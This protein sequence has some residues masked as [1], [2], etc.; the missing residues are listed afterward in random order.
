MVGW[1]RAHG[2]Q[3]GIFKTE[4]PRRAVAYL[5]P[6]QRGVRVFLA[7]D[8]GG[9]PDL[10]PTPSTSTWAVRF[11]SVFQIAGEQVVGLD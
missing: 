10:Q 6:A 4:P 1:F 2:W 7:L 5:N 9:E 11:P 8:P 3:S